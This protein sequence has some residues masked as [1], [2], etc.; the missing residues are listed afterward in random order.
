MGV[1]I[2]KA[3]STALEDAVGDYLSCFLALADQADYFTVN[4]SSPNT[5]GLRK[6]QEESY[7][8]ELLGALQ[9][10]NKSVLKGLGPS[11]SPF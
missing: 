8:R 2:G 6:L 9:D 7:L 10:E 3:R 11:L 5:P 4:I 1:N